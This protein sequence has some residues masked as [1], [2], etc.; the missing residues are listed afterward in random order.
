MRKTVKYVQSGTFA[1]EW[2]NKFQGSS[3]IIDSMMKKIESHPIERVG[4]KIRKM[5][6]L[7]K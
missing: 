4:R 1:R 7:E 3:K 6:G 2:T 5:A